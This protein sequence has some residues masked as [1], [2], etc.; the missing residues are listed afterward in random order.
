MISTDFAPNESW[1]DAW[2]SLKLIF[3]PWRWLDGNEIIQAKNK[4]LDLLHVPRS[5][6]HV[7]PFLTGRAA[8]YHLLKSL[9]LPSGSEVLIQAFTCEAV[10]LPVLANNLKPIYID[11][12]AK[13]FSMNPIDLNNKITDKSRVLILQHTFGLTP[14]HR[15]EIIKLV[16]KHNLVLIEDI[17]HTIKSMALEQPK[18]PDF[19]LL[20]FGRSK[21]LSS[22][23]GGAIVTSDSK[24]ANKLLKA[25]KNLKFPSYGFILRLLLYKP[26]AYIIKVSYD[27]IVGKLLH[28]F[29][30]KIHLLPREITKMEKSGEYDST[31][32]KDYPNAL[33]VLL[34]HQL[35]KYDRICKIRAQTSSIYTK[36]FKNQ[37][38][39]INIPFP[40]RYPLLVN[41]RN[42]LLKFAS[43]NNIFLGKWYDQVVAPRD[44]NM[45]KLNYKK[46]SCRVAEEMCKKI[47]NLPTSISKNEAIKIVKL[48][49]RVSI[50]RLIETTYK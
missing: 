21:A 14:D 41:E 33:A 32:D 11:I 23:F 18:V 16:R 22:V 27:L 50:N 49:T 28:Y 7:L 8:L 46:G 40:L 2:L 26:L 29:V 37:G 45:S 19:Y 15:H 44:L 38:I 5:T 36:S 42:G 3:Q 31:L 9:N 39:K 12:E 20:S 43:K 6:F 47:I 13:T 24:I 10:V 1:D 25:E 30:E 17:A 35:T 48:L 34:Q 4:I